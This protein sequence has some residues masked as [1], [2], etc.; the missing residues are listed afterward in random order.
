MKTL[1]TLLTCVLSFLIDAQIIWNKSNYG[2][3]A[4]YQ[5]IKMVMSSNADIY[6]VCRQDKGSID[7]VKI[8][9]STDKGAFWTVINVSGLPEMIPTSI[10][11]SGTQMLLIG[12]GATGTSSLFTSSNQGQSWTYNKF[13]GIPDS[14]LLLTLCQDINGTAY[15]GGYKPGGSSIT[16]IVFKSINYGFSWT[17]VIT[18]GISQEQSI[19]AMTARYNKLYAATFAPS[20]RK[21]MV[22]TDEGAT[23][24][25]AGP[26]VPASMVMKDMAGAANGKIYVVGEDSGPKIY[27]SNDAGGTWS[28]LTATGWNNMVYANTILPSSG[29]ILCG[30]NANLQSLVLSTEQV[31]SVPEI[32]DQSVTIFPNPAA[33]YFSLLASPSLLN[34]ITGIEVISISGQVVLSRTENLSNIDV[35][36]LAKGL[37]YLTIKSATKSQGLTFIKH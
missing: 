8:I 24:T 13:T 27:E 22:S 5:P 2:I 35:S 17:E 29:P 19:Q 1:L 20:L 16:P 31:S 34:S 10:M 12:Q 33:D 28:E 3:P 14:Y 21:I 9:K 6:A 7:S 23:W 36:S 4:D 18:S 11:F 32:Q 25:D 26:G 15:I 30:G 37:Y